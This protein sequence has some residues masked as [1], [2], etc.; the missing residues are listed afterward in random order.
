M[1]ANHPD[2][3]N[4]VQL[5]V[6]KARTANLEHTQEMYMEALRDGVT[7]AEQRRRKDNPNGP[8][9]LHVAV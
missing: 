6:G 9:S 7:E 4:A 1:T 2:V 5:A 3:V 8:R